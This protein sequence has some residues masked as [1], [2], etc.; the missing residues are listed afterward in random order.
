MANERFLDMPSLR[1]I[2]IA[3][4]IIGVSCTRHMVCTS[5]TA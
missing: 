1:T 4:I 2:V 3:A 5:T